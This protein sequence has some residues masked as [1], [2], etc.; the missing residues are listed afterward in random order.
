[1]KMHSKRV[2]DMMVVVSDFISLH[3]AVFN[4]IPGLGQIIAQYAAQ[5]ISLTGIR[6][7]LANQLP[8]G[9]SKAS[10]RRSLEKE[11][12]KISRRLSAYASVKRLP[13]LRRQVR[14]TK[15]VL[16]QM[17]NQLLLDTAR[18]LLDKA[19]PLLPDLAGF[20]MDA[21][22]HSGLKDLADAY[23]MAIPKSRE[24]V[25]DHSSLLETFE[26]QLSENLQVLNDIL[27]EAAHVI[28][29]D[30]PEVI[31]TYFKNRKT[32]APPSRPISLRGKVSHA[33]SGIPVRNVKIQV[34]DVVATSTSKGNFR[35]PSLAA[36]IHKAI[37]SKPGYVTQEISV[38]IGVA[39]ESLVVG[40][41]MMP[42]ADTH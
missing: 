18:N 7:N 25:T 26:K 34:G 28:A 19:A 11:A 12:G 23:E 22:A 6:Q 32:L 17:S 10:L 1:M 31:R 16:N 13:D 15:S 8:P 35:F 9:A 24:A 20:K 41:T 40:I 39:G 14:F 33:L 3:A 42:V 36:G 4:A 5:V 38:L 29:E 2:L 21:A 37:C 30:E 27:D